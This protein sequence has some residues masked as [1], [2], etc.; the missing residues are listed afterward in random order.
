[1]SPELGRSLPSS[2]ETVTKAGWLWPLVVAAVFRIGAWAIGLPGDG[3]LSPDSHG[4]WQISSDLIRAYTDTHGTLL[5]LAL[6]RPPGFPALLALFRFVGD[7]Y[8]TAALLLSLLGV[9]TVLLTYQVALRLVGAR[10][11]VV[12]AWWLALSPLHVIESSF[13]LTEIAFATFVLAALLTLLPSSD[14][15]DRISTTRWIGAGL[16]MA[17]ATF[18][19]PISLYLPFVVL[20]LGVITVKS[21]RRRLLTGILPFVAAFALPIGAWVGHNYA[22]TGVAT[23]ST[24]QGANLALYR[25]VGAMT[26]QD[27]VSVQ[28]A[29]QEMRRLVAIHTSADMN[30]AEVAEVQTAVGIREILERPRG[31]AQSSIKGLGRTLVGPGTADIERRL[32]AGALEALRLPLIGLSLISASAM[33]MLSVWAILRAI[34][35][36][37][38]FL[39]IAIVPLLYLILVGSG[40]EADSRFRMPLEPLLTILA[41]SVV[42][43]VLSRHATTARPRP[44]V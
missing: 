18:I 38:R 36:R 4:Y 19:R 34:R 8:A 16:L 35:R 13:L 3:Y 24:I 7:N 9:T 22:K 30:P 40:H 14:R 31:Y 2:S 43:S 28:E 12:A 27:H 10:A 1:M 37:E 29:R 11:A 6:L 26:E 25:A 17:V 21:G 15:S 5:E 33:S 41:G 44:S 23:F 20:L 42:V 39:I 32:S